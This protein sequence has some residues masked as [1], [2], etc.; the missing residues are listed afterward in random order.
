MTVARSVISAPQAALRAAA[1]VGHLTYGLGPTH[2]DVGD[3]VRLAWEEAYG[4]PR[5]IPGL[6]HGLF[7]ALLAAGIARAQ[8]EAYDKQLDVED[9]VNV[10]ALIADALSARRYVEL[11]ESPFLGALLCAPTIHDPRVATPITGHIEVVVGLA[12]CA[13]W[14]PAAPDYALLDTVGLCGPNGR[15]PGVLL[16]TGAYFARHA[17][18]WPKLEHTTRILRV[19]M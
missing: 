17:K 9:D 14:D 5:R 8:A 6:N 19:L 4:M 7:A 11:A 10:N 18:D 3:C 2:G 13:E 16:H 1:L 15:T 12:R